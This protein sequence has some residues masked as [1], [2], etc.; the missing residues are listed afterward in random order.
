MKT[1]VIVTVYNEQE[2]ILALLWGLLL[3]TKPA[4]E[5]IIVDGGSTDHTVQL[6]ELFQKKHPDFPLK[7]YIQP[8]NRSQGRNIAIRQA[9]HEWI[10]MTDAGCVPHAEWLE[11]LVL[12]A[13]RSQAQVVAGYYQAAA[14]TPFQQAVT[15]YMLIMPDR[16][17]S[18]HFLPAARSML[19]KKTAWEQVGGFD[20]DL[21][22]SEDYDLAHSLE[23]A[24]FKLAFTPHALV[25]WWPL[26]TWSQFFHTTRRIARFDTQ[27]GLTR[28]KTYLVFCRYSI[29]LLLIAVFYCANW[30]LGLAF[31]LGVGALYSLWALWKNAQYLDAGWFYLPLLQIGADLGVMIGTVRGSLAK[32]A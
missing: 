2:L 18:D 30:W 7:L 8:S 9:Q 5:V 23:K 12:E 27:A 31:L 19:L 32:K 17:N 22:V 28:V 11:Q 16:V 13:E 1:S 21:T 6:I 14:E 3:Q 20:E 29:F 25:S 15:P 10:A 4:E 24:G 26:E